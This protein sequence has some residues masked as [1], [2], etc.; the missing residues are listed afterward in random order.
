MYLDR[1]RNVLG[2]DWEQDSDG[3]VLKEESDLFRKKLNTQHL[4]EDWARNLQE[5]KPEWECGC[6]ATNFMDKD[7]CRRCKG[8][9]PKAARVRRTWHK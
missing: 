3:K 1:V 7:R 4:Y 6:G 9:R 2:E 5:R 8:T